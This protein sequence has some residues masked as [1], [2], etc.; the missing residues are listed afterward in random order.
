MHQAVSNGLAHF[1]SGQPVLKQAKYFKL[2][3]NR[4][5]PQLET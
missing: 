1:K 3:R 4:N 5:A 2:G